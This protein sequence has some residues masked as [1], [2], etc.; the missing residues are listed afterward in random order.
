MAHIFNTTLC[1]RN[2]PPH[3]KKKEYFQKEDNQLRLDQTVSASRSSPMRSVNRYFLSTVLPSNLSI[4]IYLSLFIR[5]SACPVVS[6]F[7]HQSIHPSLYQC[8]L[9]IYPP[10]HPPV[11]T[12][13]INSA[14]ENRINSTI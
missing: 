5:M 2:P 13:V 11:V 7:I 4:H 10:T 14:N 3:T 9:H 12:K 1:T 8:T 6:V